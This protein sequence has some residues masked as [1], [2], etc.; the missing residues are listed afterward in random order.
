VDGEVIEVD[1]PHRLVLTWRMLMDDNLAREGFSRLTYELQEM[2]GGGATRLTVV[3][4]LAQTP[5]LAAVVAG[6]FEEQGA[7]GGWN[8]VLSDLKSLLETGTGLNG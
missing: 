8:W 3:H 5:G 1:P 4:D 7:G 2:P 6:T